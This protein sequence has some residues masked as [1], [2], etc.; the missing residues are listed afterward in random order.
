MKRDG[1]WQFYKQSKLYG[2]KLYTELL[3][4]EA[5]FSLQSDKLVSLRAKDLPELGGLTAETGA[6]EGGSLRMGWVAK[7][8]LSDDASPA[9]SSGFIDQFFESKWRMLSKRSATTTTCPKFDE[10]QERFVNCE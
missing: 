7:K 9:N 6:C 1:G 10:V 8:L 4:L 2:L 3:V 5:Q